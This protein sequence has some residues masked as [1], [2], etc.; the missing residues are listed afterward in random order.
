MRRVFLFLGVC[1]L[2]FG[3]A[4]T[5]SAHEGSHYGHGRGHGGYYRD[6]GV[7]FS[8]GWYYRG[9]DHHH[10]SRTVWDARCHRYNYY[11]PYLHCYYYWSPVA[12]CYYPVTYVAAPPVAVV[13]VV[14][15]YPPYPVYPV[16]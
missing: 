9:R 15:S 5:A 7:R 14:P 4:G 10:W 16:P 3:L 13:P 1:V 12:N 8:G 6:H 11:D 2:G